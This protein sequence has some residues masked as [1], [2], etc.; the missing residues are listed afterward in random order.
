MKISIASEVNRVSEHFGHCEG[1]IVYDIND[2][3]ILN[4]EKIKNPGHRPGFLPVFLKDLG[5]NTIIAGGMGE[6]AQVLFK[7]NGINVIVAAN[8]LCDDVIQ[9]YLNGELKST[10]SV[11]TE[12]QHSGECGNHK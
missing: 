4:S 8:G 6:A 7:Q 3:T 10:E 1:F 12:H 2:K 5:V 11:C 9:K